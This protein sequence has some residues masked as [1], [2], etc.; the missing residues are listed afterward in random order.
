MLESSGYTVLAACHAD[1]ALLQ[2]ERG[3]ET[4]GNEVLRHGVLD[5]ATHVIGK[6]YGRAG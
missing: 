3:K 5:H 2:L 4:V 6:P 1:E